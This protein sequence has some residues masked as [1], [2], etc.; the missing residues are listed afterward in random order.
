MKDHSEMR[1]GG[2]PRNII[3]VW[4]VS[5]IQWA[6]KKKTKDLSKGKEKKRQDLFKLLNL[7]R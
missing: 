7:K 2:D 1:M 5:I 6:Q 3:V 4:G